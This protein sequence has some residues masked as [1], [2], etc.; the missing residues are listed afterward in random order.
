MNMIGNNLDAIERLKELG[1]YKEPFPHWY[2]SV[3]E[4]P[5]KNVENYMF[6][7]DKM[8]ATAMNIP[9]EKIVGT[10][11]PSYYGHTWLEML[12]YLKRY[13]G[14]EKSKER[15]LQFAE[16]VIKE[17]LPYYLKYGDKYFIGSGNHRTCLAKFYDIKTIKAEVCEFRKDERLLELCQKMKGYGFELEFKDLNRGN[18]KICKEDSGIDRATQYEF[19]VNGKLIWLSDSK[20]LEAFIN[21]YDSLS[22]RFCDRVKMVFKM[23]ASKDEKLFYTMNDN[24]ERQLLRDDLI[25]HKFRKSI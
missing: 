20:K 3:V 11:H 1:C 18:G 24:H 5:I 7:I 8:S 13:R 9:V 25:R 19:K 4:E 6:Y 22:L 16:G 12:M 23:C 17:C 15:T 14:L 10:T 2:F 21:Y